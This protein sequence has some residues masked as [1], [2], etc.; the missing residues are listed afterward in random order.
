MTKSRQQ[1]VKARACGKAIIVGEHAVVYGAE[2][3]AMPLMSLQL[4]LELL[5][6][7]SMIAASK[8]PQKVS[9]QLR[10]V[11][12][13]AYEMLELD[14]PKY[15]IHCQSQ[16]Q[17]GAG[18]GSSAALCIA[19]LRA[20]CKSEHIDLSLAQLLTIATTLEAHFHG[21]SSGLDIAVVGL[22]KIIAFERDKAPQ[23]LELH[24]H[25]YE[26][27]RFALIDSG[28]RA[29]TSSMIQTAAPFFKGA[30]GSTHIDMFN[31]LALEVRGALELYNFKQ[32]AS[33]LNESAQ[34]LDAAG[35]VT[36][37][38]SEIMLELNK[39]N[40]PASKPTGAGGGGFILALLDPNN[41]KML[42][43]IR[44]KFQGNTVIEVGLRR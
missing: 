13:H 29:S 30:K 36:N 31:H 40:I 39:L 24:P 6:K 3:I 4:D 2:A 25:S 21:K 12:A 8:R 27:I 26:K 37:R 23:I 1:P 15:D 18:L 11:I 16:I 17:I 38:L 35:V 28:V 42:D 34:L 33:A 14:I 41:P 10:Q 7:Q 44:N 20:I 43:K 19:L 5:N 9:E 22:E 32:L